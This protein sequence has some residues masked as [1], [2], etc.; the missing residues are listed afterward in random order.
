[1]AEEIF[2]DYITSSAA[3]K[4]ALVAAMPFYE[5]NDSFSYPDIKAAAT[6]VKDLFGVTDEETCLFTSSGAEAVSI[7]IT[8]AFYDKA[9]HAGKNH[10]VTSAVSESAPILTVSSLEDEGCY[11]KVAPCQKLGFMT[12]SDIIE[13]IS[14]RTALISLPWA[15]ALTGVIQPLEDIFE[16]CRERGIWL[17][18]DATHVAGKLD[19][20]F[21]DLPID[22]LT[23]SGHGIHAPIGTGAIFAKKH[24]PL[25]P[26][27]FA[28]PCNVPMI[29]ALGEAAFL[30][31]E[32]QGLY[33]TEVARLRMLF[34]EKICEAYP[35]AKVLFSDVERAPHISCIAFA[36]IH[37]NLL[38]FTLKRKGISLS[39]GGGQFLPI[40]NIL[41]ASGIDPE[42][43]RCAVTFSLSKDTQEHELER[44]A[45]IIG[46]TVKRLRR[47]S[48]GV[49]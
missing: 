27:T 37:Q 17:H 48:R 20:N 36:G 25:R 33:C 45:A 32:G 24:I 4:N 19:I 12:S 42:L 47:I 9:L 40:E 7:A 43:A 38:A 31:K 15:S 35:E 1:M 16:V 23:F 2:L 41:E 30:A 22:I 29:V 49:V 5:Q 44:A 14:P 3:T 18:V 21:H 46:E 11:L 26:I 13:S 6:K 39:I 10:F 34:E 28:N 8:S